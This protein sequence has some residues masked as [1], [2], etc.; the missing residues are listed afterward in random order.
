M[1]ATDPT[2]AEVLAALL[3]G[4]GGATAAN[5]TAQAT[6]TGAVAETAPATDTAS[7]GLNGRLQRI[8]QRL[9]SLIA[10]QS[11]ASDATRTP[12]AAAVADTAIL[13]ADPSRIGA[14]VYNESTA[15]LYL[16]Y[17]TTA[18]SPTNYSVQVTAGA[19]LEVPDRFVRC[20]IRGYWAAANGA[21]RV[22]VG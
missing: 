3:T 11:G 16:G 15:V 12:V 8:A 10:L 4:V 18:V 1:S 17:G 21:A 5:Q 2:E 13:A 9:T 7:S 22:T 14:T 6:L 19:W 20:A